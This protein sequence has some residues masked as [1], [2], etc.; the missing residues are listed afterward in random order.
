MIETYKFIQYWAM[1]LVR[2]KSADDILFKIFSNED[3]IELKRRQ[4][5]KKKVSKDG[6]IYFFRF[7]DFSNLEDRNS[8]IVYI[9]TKQKIYRT[10]YNKKKKLS[11]MEK[12]KI[13]S[14]I[15]IQWKN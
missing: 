13:L 8:V 1:N 3:N 14:K 6:S 2:K 10:M 15:K 5:I 7:Q 11:E 12:Q 9:D 4:Y